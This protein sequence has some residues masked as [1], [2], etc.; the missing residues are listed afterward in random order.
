ASRRA[1]RAA[2]AAGPAAPPA[3]PPPRPP[4]PP[5]PPP[6]PARA[7]RPGVASAV[8]PA[9]GRFDGRSAEREGDVEQPVE[10]RAARLVL[11]ERGCERLTQ[12]L[13]LD[14]G[15]RDRGDRVHAL[16]HGH[17]RAVR[18]Q[19]L[20]ELEQAPAHRRTGRSTRA[21]PP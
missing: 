19:R 2:A 15:G 5:P 1:P 21:A 18:P 8:A 7:A 12:R 9:A 3:P 13:A 16:G 4:P 11:D 6:P 17:R 14:T 10:V 20:R